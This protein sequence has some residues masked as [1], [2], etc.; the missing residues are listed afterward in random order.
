MRWAG[1]N[2]T[3][4]LNKQNN[5]WAAKTLS[6]PVTVIQR[7]R[8]S[9]SKNGGEIFWLLSDFTGRYCIQNGYAIQRDDSLLSGIE[10]DGER[11]Y[12]ATQNTAQFKTYELFTSGVFHLICSDHIWL[13]VTNHRKHKPQILGDCYRWTTHWNRTQ[14]SKGI[15]HNLET[16]KHSIHQSSMCFKITSQLKGNVTHTRAGK[17]SVNRKQPWDNLHVEIREN[18]FRAAIITIS[19]GHKRKY[20]C[21]EYTE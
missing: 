21:N 11:F 14:V 12:N 8:S 6:A 18:N 15:L 2:F 19:K 10:Q 3:K 7:W 16:Q 20:H 1:W 13:W 9:D 4:P 5:A 17:K